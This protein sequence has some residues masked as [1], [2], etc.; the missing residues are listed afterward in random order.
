MPAA[1]VGA[2]SVEMA[3]PD[4]AV[5]PNLTPMTPATWQK[6]LAGSKRTM[7]KIADFILIEKKG[8]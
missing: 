4:P 3:Y 1:S 6:A 5:N 8:G 2:R 7:A